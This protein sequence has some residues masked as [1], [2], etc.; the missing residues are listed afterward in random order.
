MGAGCRIDRCGAQARHANA[1]LLQSRLAN[2]YDY[3]D[4][5]YYYDYYY[6]D[7]Y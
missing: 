4:D 2:C 7:D 1:R 3:Y 6:D 5:D